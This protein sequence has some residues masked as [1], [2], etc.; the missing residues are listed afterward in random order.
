MIL[1]SSPPTPTL[2][3]FN[4]N[5]GTSKLHSLLPEIFDNSWIISQ[6]YPSRLFCILKSSLESDM[7]GENTIKKEAR[8]NDG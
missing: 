2:F 4:H 3:L 1:F 8:R 6:K 7:V 5:T